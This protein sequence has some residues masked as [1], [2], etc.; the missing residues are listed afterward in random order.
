MPGWKGA[1]A[2]ITGHGRS[3]R[4]SVIVPVHNVE[5][6]LG[7]CLDSLLGQTYGDFEA[8]IVLDGPTDGSAAIAERYAARDGRL[9]LIRQDNAGLGAARN[10]GVREA[11]G[12]YLGFLDA[13]DTLPWDAYA[14]LMETIERTGSDQVI[15]TLARS[16]GGR[17]GPMRLM[18]LNHQRR[19]ERIR[20]VDQP[21]L[22]ADVFAVNKVFRRTF[23]ERTGLEFPVGIRYEDQP[24]L[25]RALIAAERIDV[26]PETVYLWRIRDDQSSITQRRHELDDLVDRIETKRISTRSVQEAGIPELLDPWFRDI[27]PVDMWEYFRSAPGCSDDYWS[28]L[29]AAVRELW[30]DGTARFEDTRVPVQQRLMGWLVG[31]GRRDD[32]SALIDF[33][34]AQDEI[35]VEQRGDRQVAL[36]PGVDDPAAGLPPAAYVLG[37]H[38]LRSMPA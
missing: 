25:T 35:P 5:A 8:I 16:G 29:Q 38:E 19:R 2:R 27:L 13:D 22:L 4:L 32:L 17:R 33:L 28:T 12:E 37:D 21:L 31:Q 18:R 14:V 3:P 20:L 9:R 23:W 26:V 10:A 11:R 1:L 34:D 7:E 15:G 6:F 36:L 24:T 30:H